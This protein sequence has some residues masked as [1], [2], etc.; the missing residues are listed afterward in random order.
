MKNTTP[1]PSYDGQQ[2]YVGIDVH[3]K[4]YVVV[5]RVQQTVVKKWTTAAKPEELAVQ[6]SPYH[7]ARLFKQSTGMPPHQYI[8]SCWIER[9][10]QLLT[11]QE[12]SIIEITQQVG[13]QSQSHLTTLFRRFLKMT[14]REYRTSL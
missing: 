12:L 14:P 3:K 9:A 7:F 10:K 6:I 5:V 4:S 8:I 2:V 1:N 11:Q 13:L